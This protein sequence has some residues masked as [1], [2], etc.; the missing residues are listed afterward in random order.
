M[1]LLGA[2]QP[3]EP[4]FDLS[5][6]A[7]VDGLNR[8]AF[9]NRYKDPAQGMRLADSALCYIADSL[10]DY[11]DGWLRAMNSKAFCAYMLSDAPLVR[12][13]VD[14]ILS[15]H[16]APSPNLEIERA[17]SLLLQARLEQRRC[18]IAESYQILSDIE[19]SG[20]LD[21]NHG[22]Y[23][24]SLAQGEYYITSLILNYHYRNGTQIDGLAMLREIEEQRASLKCD[25]AQDMAL[26]YAMAHSYVKLCDS[27]SA[28]NKAAFLGHALDLCASNLSIL[29]VPAS[30]SHY[31]LADVV[32]LLGF[33]M[34]DPVI[35]SAAWAANAAKTDSILCLL[36]DVF[37]LYL[38]ADEDWSLRLLEES[39]AMFWQIDDPYQ[40]IGSVVATASYAMQT[41]DTALARYY[42]G[43]VVDH[44][45]YENML[46]LPEYFAPKFEAMLYAGLV[47][48]GYSSDIVDYQRWIDKEMA[49]QNYISG[50][51]RAD[52]VLR[53]ELAQSNRALR[54]SVVFALC[55][56]LLV[57]ALVVTLM[58]LHRKTKALAREKK[59][60]EQA[61][62]QD[63][64]RIANVETCLSVLRHD[65][66]PFVSYLQ[67][68]KLPDDL[69]Q[70]VLDRLMRTF[71]NIKSWTNLSIPSGLRFRA[72]RFSLSEVFDEA[73]HHVV[74]LHPDAVVLTF[75]PTDIAVHGDRLL[76][77]ILLRNLVNNALQ[78]TERGSVT[79]TA[80]PYKENVR[81]V[82][83]TVKDT[84]SGMTPE[85]LED[86][87]RTDKTPSSDCQNT[88][89]GFGLILCRYIIKQ[90]D[91]N[92][93]RGCRI[94]AE[95]TVG[96]GSRLCFLIEQSQV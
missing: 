43:W 67:N 5:K 10:P 3:K 86:L 29:S 63:V 44:W 46:Y 57:L 66:N 1:L 81:F 61:K 95:S 55:V 8:G 25:Y 51:Q 62:R 11:R 72:E 19:A 85:V 32:Q 23:L 71:D 83:V 52:F 30:Y 96:A 65:I 31:Q 27:A 17:I 28:E 74:N 42:Y 78:H 20:V 54:F 24:Y 35:D 93:L 9:L 16:R 26:N 39:T 40:H 50:N 14:T 88:G 77:T 7:R 38:H 58:L 2:C 60:L 70:E 82:Q 53:N 68:K 92:T 15:T 33:M 69:R 56:T 59:Q 34:S 64:E 36:G 84:G 41:G 37:G 48:S 87:F 21:R 47:A 73:R 94:W 22:N 89:H 49:I 80:Q 13:I 90:H 4:S 12:S 6:R 18:N 91:D 76:I 75:E 45:R 79:V